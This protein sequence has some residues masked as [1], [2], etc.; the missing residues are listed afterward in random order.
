MRSS[1]AATAALALASALATARAEAGVA[2]VWA[3]NDGEKVKQDDLAHPAKG[4]NSAW[5]GKTIRLFGAGNEVIAV[6]V[7]VEAD[8]KGIGA[9]SASMPGL[10]RRGGEGRIAYAP[11]AADPS[12]AVGRPIQLFSVHYMNVTQPTHADWAWKPDSPASPKDLTGWKPVQLVPENARA[13][14]GGFP[15][16]VAPRRSQ[17]VWIEVYTGRGR[18]PGIYEGALALK[19]DGETRGVPVELELMDFTLPDENS[20]DA[21]V[22]Y[23]PDQA[24]LYQGTPTTRR[25]SRRIPAASTGPTSRAPAAT[26]D[27]ARGSATGSRPPRSTAPAGAGTTGPRRGGARTPG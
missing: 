20:M 2:A 1:R 8:A 19:A 4:R 14:R 23:E 3:V 17:A 22:Y 25:S 13:G 16:K 21:M 5:D 10:R 7:I 9:L 11:P 12:D 24:E 27:P 6:Q 15:L 18:R 26:R